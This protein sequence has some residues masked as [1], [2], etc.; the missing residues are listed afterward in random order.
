MAKNRRDFP[1]EFKGEAAR[2][3]AGEGKR[4]AEVGRDAGL[5][6]SLQGSWKQA[7]AIE[8]DQALPARATSPPSRKSCAA[9]A[10]KTSGSELSG[11]FQET[12][13][14][15]SRSCPFWDPL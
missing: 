12:R 8:G 15:P 13:R 11:R 6:E 1:R 14:P 2:R 9:S 5:G 10:P 3:I 7:L 4:P